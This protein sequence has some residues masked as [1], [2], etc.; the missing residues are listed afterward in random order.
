MTLILD[1]R[2][3]KAITPTSFQTVGQAGLKDGEFVATASVFGNVDSYGDR[4]ISGAFDETLAKWAAKGDP[5]PIVFSHQWTNPMAHVG[6]VLEI[7]EVDGALQYKGLLDMDDEYSAKVYKLMKGRR[8][9]QQSFGYDVL[10]YTWSAV[11]GVDVLD[12]TKVDLFEVGP[13]L[14]GVNQS[15]SLLD[16]K[17]SNG[18]SLI[19]APPTRGQ[20]TPPAADAPTEGEGSDLQA[21]A[22]TGGLSPASISLL[23]DLATLES[24]GDF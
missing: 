18:A 20:I 3:F 22:S 16:I 11:D 17:S 19:E 23:L 13:C 8:V 21:S 2:R 24:E 14:V 1:R 15:T 10:D 9:T 7:G 12:I 5:I 4:L 6:E